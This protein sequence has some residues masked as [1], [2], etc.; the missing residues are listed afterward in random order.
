MSK[1]VV[2]QLCDI[3]IIVVSLTFWHRQE[4]KMATTYVSLETY[5]QLYSRAPCF[6]TR[7]YLLLV[8]CASLRKKEILIFLNRPLSQVKNKKKIP[9]IYAKA[10]KRA[11]YIQSK[12]YRRHVNG[13]M[14]NSRGQRLAI[15]SKIFWSHRIGII[16][17][18][19][20]DYIDILLENGNLGIFWN[21]N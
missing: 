16:I 5:L 8:C 19:S 4:G 17:E 12:I 2:Y 3:I 14:Y 20:L 10:S 18:V 1:K 11:W 6:W 13:P 9:D 7:P 21:W 15:I